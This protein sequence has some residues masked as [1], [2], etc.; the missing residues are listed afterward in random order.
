MKRYKSSRLDSCLDSLRATRLPAMVELPLSCVASLTAGLFYAFV[1]HYGVVLS[2]NNTRIYSSE[3]LAIMTP[4]Q[5]HPANKLS[6]SELHDEICARLENKEA[7]EEEDDDEQLIQRLLSDDSLRRIVSIFLTKASCNNNNNHYYS[8]LYER[9]R[10]IR[11][12]LLQLPPLPPST[13]YHFTISLILPAYK[14]TNQQV[15]STLQHAYKTALHPQHIQVIVVNAG[16]CSEDLQDYLQQQ[17]PWERHQ[18]SSSSCLQ[19]IESPDIHAG[20]GPALNAGAQHAQG[21]FLVFLHSD[22]KTPVHWDAHIVEGLLGSRSSESSLGRSNRVVHA[23]CFRF[24]FDFSNDSNSNNQQT[25]VSQCIRP[26]P[27]PWVLLPIQWMVNLRTRFLKLPYGDQVLAFPAAYF[28]HLGGFPDQSI[29]E[30]YSFMDYLRQRAAAHC[31]LLPGGCGTIIREQL[32]VLPFACQISTRRWQRVGAVYMTLANALL[33]YRYTCRN[34]SVETIF[35][36]YYRR[37]FE[38]TTTEEKK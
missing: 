6:C 2:K 31:Q 22:T 11:P 8:P 23:T 38:N 5:T 7:D 10:R 37:P 33:V 24:G 32:V 28:H 21:R 3:S 35:D 17:T 26:Y 36:H 1:Y 27:S 30:D 20:R 12:R 29:M 18:T 34:W 16:Y 15:A 19:V 13:S 9:L 4:C 14:E 25:S